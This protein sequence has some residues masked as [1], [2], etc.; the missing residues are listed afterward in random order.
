MRFRLYVGAI[1]VRECLQELLIIGKDHRVNVALIALWMTANQSNC[2][3]GH[4]PVCLQLWEARRGAI[5]VRW[6][7]VVNG[8]G[9]KSALSVMSCEVPTSKLC[10][11]A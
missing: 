6:R 1:W 10:R 4:L 11:Q 9:S 8:V 7:H 5:G 2:R 3:N